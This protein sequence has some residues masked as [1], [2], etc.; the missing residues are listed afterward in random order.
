MCNETQVTDRGD[1]VRAP[2]SRPAAPIGAAFR[3]EVDADRAVQHALGVRD[4]AR[5]RFA[6]AVR[7]ERERQGLTLRAL[8]RRCQVSP[9]FLGDLEHGRRWSA[10]LAYTL[11]QELELS[12]G[13]A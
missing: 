2:A 6:Q 9:G 3:R 11:V 4:A 13:A 7:A 8:A 10:V 1:A 5:L 12:R